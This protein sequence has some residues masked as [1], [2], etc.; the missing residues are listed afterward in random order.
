MFSL[1]G[2]ASANT[3]DYSFDN[4]NYFM[5]TQNITLLLSENQTINIM[6]DSWLSGVSSIYF[7]GTNTSNHIINIEVPFNFT[8]GSYVKYVYYNTTLNTTSNISFGF[9]INQSNITSFPDLNPISYSYTFNLS[10]MPMSFYK[11]FNLTLD[12]EQDYYVTGDSSVSI[13][14]WYF[15]GTNIKGRLYE[16]NPLINVPPSP[17]SYTR[18]L[19]VTGAGYLK[20]VYFYF[21]II[22]DSV[23]PSPL[24]NMTDQ[25][26]LDY[27]RSL[28][29]GQ[30]TIINNT[31]Y[32]TNNTNNLSVIEV[33]TN[34]EAFLEWYNKID[35]NKMEDLESQNN[36]LQTALV[37]EKTDKQTAQSQADQALKGLDNI[38]NEMSNFK[39]DINQTIVNERDKDR[40]ERSRI[41]WAFFGVILLGGGITAFVFYANRNDYP[42]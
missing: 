29:A 26:V 27:F 8:N 31:Q 21:T 30:A 13:I 28:I 32:I 23:A 34:K 40:K 1:I 9:V 10:Q 33:P 6:Y 14:P 18:L 41:F 16:L 38:Q 5:T 19:T 12:V 24:A 36:I 20:V 42:L 15:N 4:S 37:N 25:Q 22:N 11:K 35:P 7:N 3:Y 39:N 2:I 17:G